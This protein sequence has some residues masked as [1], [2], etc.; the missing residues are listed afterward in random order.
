MRGIGPG[1]FENIMRLIREIQLPNG[2]KTA[3]LGFGCAGLLRL[4]T[5]RQRENLLRT[6]VE[7]GLTHFDVARMYGM[8]TAEGIVGSWLKPF[9][10][11]DTLARK[12]GQTY[13]TT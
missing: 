11:Q 10:G 2:R 6:A 5:L 3:N 4:P 7:V 1:G 9:R 8:G 13:A 12:F